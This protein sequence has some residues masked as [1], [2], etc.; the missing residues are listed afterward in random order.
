MSADPGRLHDQHILLT[1]TIAKILYPVSNFDKTISGDRDTYLK[2]AR[3][4]YRRLT[5]APLRRSLNTVERDITAKTYSLIKYER[6]PSMAMNSY[7]KLFAEK[8]FDRF[9]KYLENVALGK[10]KISGAVLLP[11]TLVKAVRATWQIAY[12]M[13]TP[14]L[15]KKGGS[16]RSRLIAEK[17]RHSCR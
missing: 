14:T 11:S 1:T 4:D 15:S 16:G 12:R 13:H 6:V 2:H 7:S 8:D 10:S 3:E 17:K 5:L 9:N